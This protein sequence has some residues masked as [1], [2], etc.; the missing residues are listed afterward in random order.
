MP[1]P[2]WAT[3]DAPVSYDELQ[4][5]TD[6]IFS[7]AFFADSKCRKGVFGLLADETEDFRPIFFTT[8]GIRYRNDER[9]IGEVL[10]AEG[11]VTHADV[12]ETL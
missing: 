7:V 12:A 3:V 4:T 5:I 1:P 6:E 9:L 10:S 11:M 2:A 8:S